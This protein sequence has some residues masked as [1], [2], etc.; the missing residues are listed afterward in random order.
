[1]E[2][3][4]TARSKPA[5]EII[6]FFLFI[7]IQFNNVSAATAPSNLSSYGSDFYLAFPGNIYAYGERRLNLTV[8]T[9]VNASVHYSIESLDQ[10]FSYSGTTT[11]GNP[12]V[13]VIPL[14]YE[15]LFSNY[16]YRKLGLHITSP[17]TDPVSVVAWN[18]N[19][20][21]G[22]LS[23]LGL[24]CHIQPTNQYVYYAVSSH[25]IRELYGYI[26]LVGCMNNTNVM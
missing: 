11:A 12:D 16:S 4:G 23:F 7:A 15:V 26:V 8:H 24:P 9:L 3:A 10:G 18:D 20:V 22:Y 1:M 5:A 21:Y 13:V 6:I 2:L 25:G 17:E 19:Y 14:T